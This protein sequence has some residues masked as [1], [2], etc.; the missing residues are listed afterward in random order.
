[1]FPRNEEVKVDVKRGVYETNNQLNKATF[2][3]KQD[4]RLC[5]GVAKLESKDGTMTGKRYPVLDYTG[6]N[7]YHNRC[8][9]KM[10]SKWISKNKEAY[11]VDI[12]TGEE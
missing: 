12:H 7:Y 5:L 3:Y 10:N 2:K 8:F 4:G 6:K 1:M 9:T 11:F